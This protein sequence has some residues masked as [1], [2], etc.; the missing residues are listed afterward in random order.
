MLKKYNLQNQSLDDELRANM[1]TYQYLDEQMRQLMFNEDDYKQLSKVLDGV[2]EDIA[3]IW[4]DHYK[5]I[6]DLTEDEMYK[7]QYITNETERQLA[8]K[9]K[10]YDLARAELEVAKA[11]TNLQNVLKALE[12][13][14]EYVILKKVG[15]K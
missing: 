3:N 14:R 1:D 8:A 15:E 9:Q 2:Q 11:Q 12:I 10:E 6:N 13:I 7:A 4:E 5:Q